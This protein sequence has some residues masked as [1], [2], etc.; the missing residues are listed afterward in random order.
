MLQGNGNDQPFQKYVPQIADTLLDLLH[1]PR[2]D[3]LVAIN[4]GYYLPNYRTEDNDYNRRNSYDFRR[5]LDRH[6]APESVYLDATCTFS[7]TLGYTEDK[8]TKHFWKKWKNVFKGKKLVIICGEGILD[9]LEYNTFDEADSLK[10]I[11]GPKRDAWDKHDELIEK[12]KKETHDQ[13]LIFILGMAGKAMI[14]EVTCLG[15]TAWD[16]GH[17]FTLCANIK[18]SNR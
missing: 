6:C 14:S 1:T 13:I 11:Y 15:Y 18:D 17:V 3:M 2:P 16:I 5:F 12:I 10:Y 8:R 7:R 9:K 4:R